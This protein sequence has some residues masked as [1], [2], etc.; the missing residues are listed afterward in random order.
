MDW[1]KKAEHYKK[2]KYHEEFW[3]CTFTSILIKKKKK[4]Q[5]IKY[6][7]NLTKYIRNLKVYIKMDK[8]IVKFEDTKSK[9]KHFTDIETLY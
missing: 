1:P 6:I 7:E 5:I 4:L 3:S 2:H 8:T 9:N